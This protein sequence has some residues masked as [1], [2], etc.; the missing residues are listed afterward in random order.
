MQVKRPLTQKQTDII[1]VYIKL[2]QK[3]ISH[4]GLA[5]LK[6]AGITKDVIGHHFGSLTELRAAT[7][8]HSPDLFLNIIDAELFSPKILQSIK[9]KM[10][11]KEVFI[12]ASAVTGCEVHKGFMESIKRFNEV[13]KAMLI[14]LPCTDPAARAGWDLDPI[15][16]KTAVVMDDMKINSNCF[17]S[18]IKLSAKQLDP[19]TGLDEVGKRQGSY[20][21][22][23]PQQRMKVIPNSKSHFPRI[24]MTTGAITRPNY[25]TDRYM[26]E[27]TAYISTMNHVMGAIVVE[28]VDDKIFHF[29]QI[30]AEKSGAFVDM[31]IYYKPDGIG[32]LSPIAR[33][34]GDYHAGEHD[35]LAEAAFMRLQQDNPA[36]RIIFH[37]IFNGI[38]VNHHEKNKH[39]KRALRYKAGQL[40]IYNELRSVA[41]VLDRWGDIAERLI[42]AKSNHDEFLSGYLDEGRYVKDYPNK[43]VALE[44]ALAMIRK[45][46]PLIYGVCQMVG[47]KHDAKIK[48]L[49]R[50]DD[51]TLAKVQ[52]GDH[53]DTYAASGVKSQARTYGDAITAHIHAPEIYRGVYR[54]GTTSLLDLGYNEGPGGW[55][56]TGCDLYPNGA[57]Q[58]INIID[59]KYGANDSAKV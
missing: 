22:A 32:H 42:V 37:D 20:L 3:R 25:G 49:Q 53:G 44:L 26:S 56:H 24:G 1:K 57:R 58:L 36:F 45:K 46:D 15:L 2:I 9:Q 54:V 12:I 28:V 41:G 52:C 35:P 11:K 23:G 21:F 8:A 43:E 14:V 13:N 29:R 39:I 48:W 33:V 38:S 59:G 55:M 40:S 51:L 47:L 30:Q 17:I 4:P 31:G 7:K 10:G 16:K 18:K 34:L 6:E 27:R 19:M 5:D 50:D